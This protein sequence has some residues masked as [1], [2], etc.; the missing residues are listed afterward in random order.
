MIFC[1][2]GVWCEMGDAKNGVWLASTLGRK[3]TSFGDKVWNAV[4]IVYFIECQEGKEK[5]NV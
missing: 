1:F 2:C 5:D 3:S 4:S